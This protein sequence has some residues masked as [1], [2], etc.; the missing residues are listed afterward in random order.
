MSAT[1]ERKKDRHVPLCPHCGAQNQGAGGGGTIIPIRVDDRNSI[2]GLLTGAAEEVFCQVCGSGLGVTPTLAVVAPT[3]REVMVA[4]TSLLAGDQEIV[5]GTV[6]ELKSQGLGVTLASGAAEVRAWLMNRWHQRLP[7]L[8]E[9]VQASP[10]E[11]LAIVAA[12]MAAFDPETF[13]A[14][15]VTLSLQPPGSPI[16][17]SPDA[18]LAKALDAV[19]SLQSRS[20]FVLCQSWMQDQVTELERDLKRSVPKGG[21]LPGTA[22]KLIPALSTLIE[23]DISVPLKYRA[24][25]LLATVCHEAELQNPKGRE[26]AEAWLRHEVVMLLADSVGEDARDPGQESA[27]KALRASR[28]SKE[29]AASTL[30]RPD[31]YD[32]AARL[33]HETDSGMLPPIVDAMRRIGYEH[34]GWELIHGIQPQSDAV[35]S[36]QQLLDALA[37]SAPGRSPGSVLLVADRLVRLIPDLTPQGVWE[38]AD[39][40]AGWWP[41]SDEAAVET[42]LW[43]GAVLSRTGASDEFLGRV[44]LEPRSFEAGLPQAFRAAL[45]SERAE[46]LRSVGRPREAVELL[47]ELLVELEADPERAGWSDVVEMRRRLG[48]ALR[49]AGDRERAVAVLRTIALEGDLGQQLDTKHALVVALIGLGRLEEA[50]TVAD[51]ARQ[52]A[53]GP[54]RDWAATFDAAR[55]NI[56][57]SRGRSAE[58]EAALLS[59]PLERL[60]DPAILIPVASALVSHPTLIQTDDGRRLGAAVL[61]QLNRVWKEYGRTHLSE[62]AEQSLRLLALLSHRTGA[63][64]ELALW[65]ALAELTDISGRPDPMATI[66]LAAGAEDP[67]DA[68]VSLD[69]AYSA[70]AAAFSGAR[71]LS[72]SY[73]STQSIW[74]FLKELEAEFAIRGMPAQYQ[75]VVAELSRDMIGRLLAVGTAASA[76]DHLSPNAPWDD[77]VAQLPGRLAV[78]EWI[79]QADT[80]RLLMTVVRDG[81]VS[82]EVSTGPPVNIDSLGRR[83]MARVRGWHPGRE[84]EPFDL[85]EWRGASAWISDFVGERAETV[86]AVV[87][88]E[89]PVASRVPWHVALTPYW[90]VCSVPSWASVLTE[91]SQTPT[92]LARIGCITVPRFAEDNEILEAFET[93]RADLDNLTSTIPGLTFEHVEATDADRD[94]LRHLLGSTDLCAL[95]CHGYAPATEP[96]VAWLIADSGSLPLRGSVEAASSVGRRHQFTWADC[97]E[98]EASSALVVSAACSTASAHYAG[99][100]EQL[101]LY[102]ALRR[103]G[104]RALIAPRWDVPAAT[105]LPIFSDVIQRMVRGG[106]SP[107]SAVQAASIAVAERLPQWL[108]YAP[109]VA[110]G[111]R[112][113]DWT[114]EEV[115]DDR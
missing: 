38:L 25:A 98:L 113:D 33:L 59:I 73:L 84:G 48:S 53:R 111:W 55:A 42:E 85:A 58:A 24:N 79:G 83:I 1:T 112:A 11:Q 35:V 45:Q 30:S 14:A 50:L 74:G 88:V 23:Q 9:A 100:G 76:S 20:L 105:V 70:V 44:G 110:G 75:R 62:A 90:P 66:V 67:E 99:A 94:E 17:I 16:A 86:D 29:R 34:L 54:Y 12:N 32:A 5:A 3:D 37:P 81:D 8:V 64:D 52:I 80:L 97:E 49:Q 87:L 104:T 7:R 71:R 4:V 56:L 68:R 61:K 106:G 72:E 10:E 82:S 96:G 114:T 19:A 92:S 31:L 51:E 89:H 39:A 18:D 2:V 47:T 22:E 41:G 69:R 108:A 27:I 93:L 78:V 77:I 28:I 115:S 40:M 46:G 60:N 15:D 109:A 6:D 36:G 65:R 101:G 103:H 95:L 107:A 63:G 43:A 13:V 57:V 26:W 21:L 102:S 91:G